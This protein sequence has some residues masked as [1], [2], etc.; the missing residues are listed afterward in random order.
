MFITLIFGVILLFY[1]IIYWIEFMFEFNVP[2]INDIDLSV[3]E[4]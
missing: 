4:I 1:Y 2:T 3:I